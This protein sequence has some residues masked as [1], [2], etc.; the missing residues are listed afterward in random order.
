M[1]IAP[2]YS[3]AVSLWQSA[4]PQ[5][6]TPERVRVGGYP[7]CRSPPVS[8]R[9]GAAHAGAAAIL[10]S[11]PSGRARAPHRL[12]AYTSLATSSLR[13]SRY[14]N[15]LSRIC[16]TASHDVGR[17][18]QV[19]CP[20]VLRAARRHP[21]WSPSAPLL[22]PAWGVAGRTAA[23][24]PTAFGQ[25]RVFPTRWAPR[26]APS[27]P[28]RRLI[29]STVSP[30]LCHCPRRNSPGGG[31]VVDRTCSDDAAGLPMLPLS[32]LSPPRGLL[33]RRST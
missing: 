31:D 2:C 10:A 13:G 16:L 1:V 11:S 14:R 29:P 27:C 20:M 28:P 26:Q 3:Q 21:R 15:A 9:L 6:S 33:P 19:A 4:T 7:S 8:R 22:L 32:T 25:T 5:C 23:I 17:H 30:Q 18:P 12:P 24:R